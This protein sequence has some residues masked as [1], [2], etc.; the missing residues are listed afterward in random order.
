MAKDNIVRSQGRQKSQYDRTSKETKFLVGDHVL[1]HMP[2]GMQGRE[3]KLN[4]PFHGPYLITS[5]TDCNVE[6]Q[7]AG[8]SRASILSPWVGSGYVQVK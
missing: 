8:S 1:V 2:A 7:L 4:C 6:V 3:R 5:L